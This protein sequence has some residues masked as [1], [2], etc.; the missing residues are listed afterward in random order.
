MSDVSQRITSALLSVGADI[1]H[2]GT[3]SQY[4]IDSGPD[5]YAVTLRISGPPGPP[6]AGSLQL[7]EALPKERGEVEEF[8]GKLSAELN[9]YG[10]TDLESPYPFLH[11]TFY[12]FAFTDS[13]G[14]GHDFEYRIE[15]A[16]HLDERYRRLVEEFDEF[17]ESRR[18]FAKFFESRRQK[19]RQ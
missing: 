8:L 18:V 2:G 12:T 10:L 3:F 5:G 6:G 17:F 11:P 13:E 16:N 4:R 19:G 9:V 7:T 1:G 14:G 15:C